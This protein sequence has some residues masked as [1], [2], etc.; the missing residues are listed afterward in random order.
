MSSD[1]QWRSRFLVLTLARLV[2]LGAFL[3][4]VAVMYTDL[5]R[6]GGWRQ[7]GAIFAIVGALDILLVPKILRK[8]WERHD[9]PAVELPRHD[10]PEWP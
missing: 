4:G 8:A 10:P 3:F 5:L 7:V 9:R 6:E 1:D 2:G